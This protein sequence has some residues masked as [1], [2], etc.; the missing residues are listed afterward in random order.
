M[1]NIL[2]VFRVMRK[3]LAVINHYTLIKHY[4]KSVNL[5]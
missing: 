3:S 4:N 5:G 1:E 2:M